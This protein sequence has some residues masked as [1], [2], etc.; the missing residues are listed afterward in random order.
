MTYLNPTQPEPDLAPASIRT[1]V[2]LLTASLRHSTIS[3]SDPV[4]FA[5]ERVTQYHEAGAWVLRM[6]WGQRLRDSSTVPEV[7]EVIGN[8]G[9][10]ADALA[11]YRA[12][13]DPKSRDYE[14]A[15]GQA[16]DDGLG[17][18]DPPFRYARSQR[19]VWPTQPP[20]HR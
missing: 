19:F 11:R 2:S 3:S 15:R 20:K 10:F 4:A 13:P 12:M 18:R 1:R 14:S 5:T 9:P 6:A 16:S 7:I 17:H 8:P